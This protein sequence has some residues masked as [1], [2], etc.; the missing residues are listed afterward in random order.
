LVKTA[1]ANVIP[2][3][4]DRLIWQSMILVINKKT[5]VRAN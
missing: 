1:L 4:I 2:K 3:S 5:D